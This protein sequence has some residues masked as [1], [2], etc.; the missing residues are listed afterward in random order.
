MPASDFSRF[1]LAAEAMLAVVLVTLH[2]SFGGTIW[3]RGILLV[4][5]CG[6]LFLWGLGAA[7]NHR[8]WGW[9][10]LLF[11]PLAVLVI[12]LLQLVP[13]PESFHRGFSPVAAELRDFSLVPLGLGRLRPIS[14]DP[15][16]TA[17]GIARLAGLTGLLVTAFQLGR[18]PG[19]RRRLFRVLALSGLSI[20]LC[21]FIHLIASEGALFGVHKFDTNVPFVTPFWN[22]NHLAAFLSLS[23]TVALALALDAESRDKAIGWGLSAFA[24]GVGVF[25]TY[26]RGGITTFVVTWGLVGAAFLARKAG[27][28]RAV[29]PWV[30]IVAT[31]GF[32]GLLSFE[33]LL[34]RAHSVS[35][36]EKLEATKVDLWP[37]FAK[38]AV[39]FWRT[40]MGVGAFEMGFSQ[41][42]TRE[43]SVTFTHPENLP[44]QWVSEVG[45]PLTVFLLVL[46]AVALWRVWVA[47]RSSSLERYVALS[48]VGLVLHELFDFAFE[49]EALGASVAI[50]AGLL[51]STSDSLPRVPAERRGVWLAAA[52][53]V[54][55]VA[56]LVYGTPKH[57]AAERALADAIREKRGSNEVR[58]FA[59]PLIDRHPAD[60]VLYAN[61]A[62]DFARRGHPLEA[63]A[64]TNRVLF[65]RPDDSRVHV[66]AAHALLRL[67]KPL[68]ALAELKLAWALGDSSSLQLGL[69]IAEKAGA[70]DRVLS[71]KPGHLTSAYVALR[72]RAKNQQALTLLQTA[73]EFSPS[74][75]VRHEAQVLVARHEAELGDPEAAM[76]LLDALS[77]AAR[78]SV[79][80]QLVRIRLLFKL[81]RADEGIAKLER[82]QARE[83]SRLDVGF[84]L[85][86]GLS[87]VGRVLAAIDVL[88]RLDPFVTGPAARSALFQREADLWQSQER[89]GRAID[90]LQTASRL[91]PTR[92]DLHYRLATL[93]ERMERTHSALEEVHR[94]RLLDTSEGAK[95]KDAWV[96]RLMASPYSESR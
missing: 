93:F 2:G 21:G 1:W 12:A 71:D 85:A 16:S 56:G 34:D 13:L 29:L 55:G 19:T 4:T 31:I 84:E 15:P 42:Q 82:L 11:L 68:Q 8:R 88:E 28:L 24:C 52:L 25:L 74:E 23:G 54:L 39:E 41:F 57:Q 6:S 67:G 20:A 73:S 89:W 17:R 66:A 63:L 32:A 77:P 83:P 78:A 38:G 75:E 50:L 45:L 48:L 92:A 65:L 36:L 94:G 69:G 61:V 37:M 79:D 76:K 7:R 81:R 3:A 33:E 27:S 72:Q 30:V 46:A 43:L 10:L 95:A 47:V 26:S 80:L 91:E 70:W 60:W 44:L 59:L 5:G 9:H 40:G 18:L 64:W 58:A 49:F 14:M 51:A 87:A 90:A 96:E 62:S 35:S 22:T 86:G 53:A